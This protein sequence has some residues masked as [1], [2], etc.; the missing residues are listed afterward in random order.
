M[1]SADSTARNH[2][3]MS[4]TDLA[5]RYEEWRKAD[6]KAEMEHCDGLMRSFSDWPEIKARVRIAQAE[7]AA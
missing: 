2:W 5:A 3:Q 1:H 7:V 4:A 6:N